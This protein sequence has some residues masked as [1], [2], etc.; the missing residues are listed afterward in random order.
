[1]EDAVKILAIGATGFIG[2]QVVTL[3][4]DAGHEVAVLHRSQA[5]GRLPGGVRQIRGDRNALP[6][7]RPEIER[8][9]PDVVLDVIPYTEGQARDLVEICRGNAG[10]IVVLS[11]AD[12]YRNYD[13]LRG[14]SSAPPDAVPLAETAPLREELYPYRGH[15]ITF[16]YREEYDKILVEQ[17]VLHQDHTP[18]TALRLP[19]VYGPGDR[20][21]RIRDYLDKMDGG[22]SSI[23]MGEG[24]AGWSWCRG[25]VGNV[26]AAIAG[27]VTRDRAA[28]RCY[29][30]ADEPTLTERQWIEAIGSAAGWKGEVKTVADPEL[31]EEQRKPFDWRYGLALDTS[32]IRSELG[33]HEVFTLPEGLRATVGWERSRPSRSERS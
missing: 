32:R 10:R 8:L 14:E 30:V 18:A 12:V 16:R 22:A 1:M 33:F 27:A 11:S 4:V 28:G 9:S 19:A 26:A 23:V 20:Q 21:R 3:L 24:E 7:L 25:Y 6:G 2:S 5:P 15:D 13:G 17:T 29:N 31:P